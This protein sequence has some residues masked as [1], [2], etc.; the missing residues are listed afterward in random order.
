MEQVKVSR[1]DLQ[2]QKEEPEVEETSVDAEKLLSQRLSSAFDFAFE[3]PAIEKSPPAVLE[4]AE[5]NHCSEEKSE[6]EDENVAF[7]LFSDINTISL[8]DQEVIVNQGRPIEFYVLQDSPE[9]QAHL[10]ASVF[11]F[12]QL[13]EAKDE[14]WPAC[15]KPQKVMNIKI[16]DGK[17]K[18]RW[19]PSKKRRTRMKILKEKQ[20]KEKLRRKTYQNKG[21][22]AKKSNSR[23]NPKRKF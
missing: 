4:V 6:S 14:P 16:D 7:N 2:V 9:R 3:P 11:T 12:E 13:M 21:F 5:S 22:P 19:R 10:R 17:K 15:Q 1:K 18:H 23:S 8:N 20:E